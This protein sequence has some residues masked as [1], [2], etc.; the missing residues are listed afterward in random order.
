M[1]L[2]L[3]AKAA[4][5]PIALRL[6]PRKA[7]F[8][9]IYRR[10]SWGSRESASGL[11]SEVII[12]AAVRRD[13]ATVIKEI[14]TRSL[15]DAPCGDFNWMKEVDVNLEDYVGVDI[16][17]E[18]IVENQCR[19]GTPN[20]CFVTLDIVSDPVPKADLILCLNC[21]I[22]LSF[23]DISSAIRNFRKS[24]SRDTSFL[25]TTTYPTIRHN[26]DIPTGD[27]R[28]INLQLLPFNFPE[29]IKLISGAHP[30]DAEKSL[31]LWSLE[32]LKDCS[33]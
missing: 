16:V 27:Y 12:T 25:L 29:P 9:L 24:G 3:Q 15:L 30:I 23:K 28:R 18:I 32:D 10:N 22:H 7:V 33:P 31:G 5:R 20:R 11:G 8:Y 21:F 19:F 26:R 2:L 1:S 4:V 13:I 17:S 14:N 6:L